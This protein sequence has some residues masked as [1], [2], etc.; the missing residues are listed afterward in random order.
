MKLAICT[1]EDCFLH[2]M[3]LGHPESPARLASVMDALRSPDLKPNLDFYQSPQASKEQLALAHEPDYIENIFA[4][5]PGF[6]YAWVDSSTSMNT[7]TLSGALHAVGALI[8]ATDLVMQGKY[9]RAFC[10][11]RPPGHHA[12]RDRAMGFCFFNNIALAALH[13]QRAYGVERVA[14][15]DFDVHHG[16]GTEEII[17]DKAGIRL[18][19]SFQN[20]LFPYSGLDPLSDRC[21]NQAMQAGST[22]LDY[23]DMFEREWLPQLQ[24]FRAE[25]YLVSAGFDAHKHDPLANIN[26]HAGDYY[27][28]TQ[29][30]VS[31]ANKTAEG[32]VISALEGGYHLEALADSVREHVKAMM[33]LN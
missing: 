13:A 14:I 25:L 29:R 32:R 8:Q 4:S 21:N 24:D 17:S 15:I 11:V 10:P 9:Q 7:F 20:P 28:I 33:E 2:E 27:W 18:F 23:Q 30:I 5:A 1:H 19:S 3:G 12:E 6:G 16:N 26:L 31:L 22:G